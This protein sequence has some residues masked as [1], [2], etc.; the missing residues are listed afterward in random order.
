M[1][2]QAGKFFIYKIIGLLS[3]KSGAFQKNH[4]NHTTIKDHG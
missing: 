3:T 1:L 2:I 4:P